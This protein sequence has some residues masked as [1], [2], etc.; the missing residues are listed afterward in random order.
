MVLATRAEESFEMASKT[1]FAPEEWKLLLESPM[2]SS[3]A[4]TAA[5]PGGLW[6][7]LK[8]SFASGSALAKAA[9]GPDA[10]SLVRA[11]ATE[12]STAEG[13]SAARDDL[14][15][16]LA[17]TKAVDIKTKSIETLKQVSALVDAKAPADA[18]AFKSWLRQISE[19][20]A[21]AAKEGG[22]M[23]FGGVNVSEGEKATLSDISRALGA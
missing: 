12:F 22:F 9:S 4:V 1:N 20:V 23:G 21:E 6:G 7:M 15:V 5:D 3:I 19:N 16:K 13:R 17:G 11:V 18:A 14:N 2:M 10:N 8:E